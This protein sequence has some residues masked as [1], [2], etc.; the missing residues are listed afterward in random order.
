VTDLRLTVP[1]ASVVRESSP[2]PKASPSKLVNRWWL[3]T[4]LA[5]TA[6]WGWKR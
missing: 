4:G 2:S 3:K 5:P 1:P 6:V